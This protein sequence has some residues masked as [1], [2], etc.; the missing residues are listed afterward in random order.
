MTFPSLR[1]WAAGKLAGQGSFTPIKASA[2]PSKT[3]VLGE[4]HHIVHALVG[5]FD[6]PEIVHE[7]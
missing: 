5:I 4:V 7:W 6:F 1:A 2:A 3:N